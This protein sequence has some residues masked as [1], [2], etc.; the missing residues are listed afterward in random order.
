MGDA[1]SGWPARTDGLHNAPVPE[2]LFNESL[3]AFPH[4]DA[5]VVYMVLAECGFNGTYRFLGRLRVPF[6]ASSVNE[7][8]KAE[9]RW[10]V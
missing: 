2:Q 4:L 5:Q 6:T 1:P 3:A 8:A 10:L 9:R 7:E